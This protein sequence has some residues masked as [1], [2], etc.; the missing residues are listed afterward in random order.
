MLL[1]PHLQDTMKVYLCERKYA[2][3]AGRK[4]KRLSYIQS[5]LLFDTFWICFR[6]GESLTES[7]RDSSGIAMALRNMMKA[8]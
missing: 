8:I 1:Q 2:A 7:E 5:W 6:A 4:P 3:K